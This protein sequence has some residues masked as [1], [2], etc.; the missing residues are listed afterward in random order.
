MPAPSPEQVLGVLTR[1]QEAAT[2][3]TREP[4]AILSAEEHRILLDLHVHDPLSAGV[5][6]SQLREHVR[7]LEGWSR[8]EVRGVNFNMYVSGARN[9]F[10][11]Q[12][13]IE[14]ATNVVRLGTQRAA[15]GRRERTHAVAVDTPVGMSPQQMVETDSARLIAI[16]LLR[17]QRGGRIWYDDFHKRC[18]TD[19]NGT[20]DGAMLNRP[21]GVDDSFADNITTWLH[22]SDKRLI[23]MTEMQVQRIIQH[24]AHFDVRN[25]PRD[26]LQEQRWDGISRLNSLFPRGFDAMDTAFNREAG[27]CWMISMIA[28]IMIP[29][30]KVDTMPVLIGGQGKAKSSALEVIGGD[31]YRA[32][33]SGVDAK[34]FLQELHGA[35]VF[36]IQELHSIIS[37]KHGAAKI[38]A[39]LSTRIDHFRVPFGR[40]AS[41]HERTA[42]L[43]GTTNNRDWHN[44]DTGGRRFWPVHVGQVD[45]E[46]LREWRGQLF[47]EAKN[48]YDGRTTTGAAPV[49]EIV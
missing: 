7:G 30:A 3:G 42:V 29:G 26:W 32:A 11:Q 36:E 40:L 34:D 41:D 43:A 16:G 49:V 48:Y 14:S 1:L 24:V 12:E 21:K 15:R 45:L 19:W 13:Q 8:P 33:S 6:L 27:R 35:L 2:N 22:E 23:K 38:K 31:W 9:Y 4:S 46:W 10:R 44:D 17:T 28:R 18:F 25:E 39:V 20:H 37:S 5:V 47:A